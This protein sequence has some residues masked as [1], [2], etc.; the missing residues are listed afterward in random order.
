MSN[1]PQ[2][3]KKLEVE[4]NKRTG[5]INEL[6]VN[7]IP[8]TGSPR[9]HPHESGKIILVTD[10]YSFHNHYYEFRKKDISYAE[11]LP[12]MA[13]MNGD[14]I[15]IFR[16]WVRKKSIAIQCTPFIVENIRHS[17]E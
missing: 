3:A 4:I 8:F 11:E 12:S 14:V 5:N 7:H 2:E 17:I 1:L 10:P 13:S 9:K 16:I 15:P 6:K